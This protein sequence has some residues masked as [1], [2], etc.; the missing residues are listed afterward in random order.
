MRERLVVLLHGGPMPLSS[1][2]LVAGLLLVIRVHVHPAV[3]R[4]LQAAGDGAVAVQRVLVE[5]PHPTWGGGIR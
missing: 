2:S 4:P 1:E 3:G 5:L